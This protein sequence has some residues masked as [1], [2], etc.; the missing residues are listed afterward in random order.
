MISYCAT[1]FGMT[2]VAGP[3]GAALLTVGIGT[4]DLAA[5]FAGLRLLDRFRRKPLFL[6]GIAAT[7]ICLV[8]LA[9]GCPGLSRLGTFGR[10][11]VAAA[12][13]LRRGVLAEPGSA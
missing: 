13:S 6:I 11:L 5:T 8:V 4:I 2:G 3:A 10:W 12:C 1:I 7:V 9:V